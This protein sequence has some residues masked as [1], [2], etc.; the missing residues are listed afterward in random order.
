MSPEQ[1]QGGVHEVR[2]GQSVDVYALGVVAFELLA[3]RLPYDLPSGP[4]LDDLRR[5][6]LFSPAR[7][8]IEFVPDVDPELDRIIAKALRK[9]PADRYFSV[10]Q[11]LRALSRSSLAPR[12]A[13]RRTSGGRQSARP[14][15]RPTGSSTKSWARAGWAKSGPATTASLKNKRIVK[16]C[17]DEEKASFLRRELTLYKLLK[18]KVGQNPHF[19]RLEEVALDE[20]P[21]YLMSEFIE[22]RD[23]SKWCA[24][25]GRAMRQS[26]R[27]RCSKS[28][29]K[30]PMRCRRP[31]TPESSTATS[32]PRTSSCA[33]IPPTS[34]ASMSGSVISA[35]ARSSPR[36]FSA[37]AP[38][39]ASPERCS[40][41]TPS[42]HSG[43][44]LYMAP[45]L[46]GGGEASVRSD[47]Y[48]LGVVLYQ[49]LAG[50]FQRGRH[51]RLGRPTSPIR[52]LRADL[53]SVSP[54]TRPPASRAPPNSPTTSAASPN[55]ATRANAKKQ[56]SLHAKSRPID[57]ALSVP[58]REQRESLSWSADWL[59]MHFIGRNRQAT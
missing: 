39:A 52:S 18:E 11:F 27:P 55:A 54:G 16:F 51:H 4:T 7:R 47:I 58:G 37:T 12:P 35:S 41:K 40:A 15:H 24:A 6:V 44:H 10:A 56:Q 2:A 9:D 48:A 22:A 19:A 8:L 46:L 49:A 30:R 50:D 53:E 3:G 32:S 1:F 28:S 57:V 59:G 17:A 43:T 34:R 29:P 42:S 23:F 33:V 26:L 38:A 21:R 45:E 25:H 36:T 31:T 5:A 14:S 13:G 20:P